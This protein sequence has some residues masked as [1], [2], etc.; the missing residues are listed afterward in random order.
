MIVLLGRPRCSLRRGEPIIGDKMVTDYTRRRKIVGKHA[1][2]R[3]SGL[4][5][6]A[7]TVHGRARWQ[8]VVELPLPQFKIRK[9]RA[10]YRCNH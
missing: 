8:L 3:Q 4:T 7:R 5:V 1:E 9:I 10:P 6:K 2:F